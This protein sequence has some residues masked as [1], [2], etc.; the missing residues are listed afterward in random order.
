M[1]FIE[2]KIVT[3][4]AMQILADQPWWEDYPDWPGLMHENGT[5]T[6]FADGH[7]EYWKWQCQE[8]VALAS[9]RGLPSNV[10]TYSHPTCKKDIVRV[11]LSVWGDSLKYTPAPSDMP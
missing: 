11:Q 3:P 4:D 10:T 6:G 5:T 1:V 2:E 7:G 9:L 8:T